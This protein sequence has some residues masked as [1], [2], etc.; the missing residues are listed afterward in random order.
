M[1]SRLTDMTYVGELLVAA[2]VRHQPGTGDR[3]DQTA[4]GLVTLE[5]VRFTEV[6]A[7]ECA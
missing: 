4:T 5:V 1:H 7:P 6:P 3:L 2:F